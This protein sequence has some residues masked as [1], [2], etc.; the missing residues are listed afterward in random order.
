M[1]HSLIICHPLNFL[2]PIYQGD[3]RGIW[4]DNQPGSIYS[5]RWIIVGP[6]NKTDSDYMRQ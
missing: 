5:F 1:F 6:C 4:L 3:A 2:R